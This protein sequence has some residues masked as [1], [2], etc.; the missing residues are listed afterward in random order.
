M[1]SLSVLIRKLY[2]KM[3]T[4]GNQA[5]ARLF[6]SKTVHPS[7]LINYARVRA[8]RGC[9]LSIGESCQI[10]GSIIFERENASVIIGKRV[11]MNGNIISAE[12]VTIGS[13]VLISW[14]VTIVDHNSHS[15]SFSRRASDVVL[16]RDQKKDWSPVKIAPVSISDK[17]W[18]GFNSI[19]LCGVMVGEGAVIGAGSVVTKDIPP[20]SIAAGNPAKIIREIP[21]EDR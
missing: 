9:A 19:I 1:T 5:Q 14:G 13:D 4:T 8:K 12:K 6:L 15:L 2:Q 21:I 16:W 3:T 18:V 10:D 17:A 7:T 11:F 20:W